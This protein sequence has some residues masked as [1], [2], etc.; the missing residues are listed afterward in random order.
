MHMMV[1][2]RLNSN[3]FGRVAPDIWDAFWAGSTGHLGCIFGRVA[4]DIM[5]EN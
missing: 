1:E 4:P 2:R 5:D 3:S